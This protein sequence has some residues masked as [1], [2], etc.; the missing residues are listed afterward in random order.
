MRLVA[1]FS[2][3]F[4]VTFGALSSTSC[5]RSEQATN[6]ST[7]PKTVTEIDHNHD[8]DHD[9][10]GHNHA[11]E[12][13]QVILSDPYHLEFLVKHKDGGINLDFHLENEETHEVISSAK[14]TAKVQLPNGEEK[15]LELQYEPQTEHYIAFLPEQEAEGRYSVTILTDING[16]QVNSNF[17][18][19]K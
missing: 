9:N 18:F 14:V 3:I 17:Y 7:S 5:T 6:S 8:H 4:L 19:D 11:N 2:L 16:E 1:K 15:T 10:D 13:T 12:N